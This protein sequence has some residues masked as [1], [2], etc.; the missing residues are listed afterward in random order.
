MSTLVTL[1]KDW[2]SILGSLDGGRNEFERYLDTN[3]LL[4]YTSLLIENK[5]GGISSNHKQGKDT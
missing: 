5:E 3:S 1:S 4:Y 2:K